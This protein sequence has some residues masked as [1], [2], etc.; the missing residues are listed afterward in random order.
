MIITDL[1]IQHI[2]NAYSKQLSIRPRISKDKD[3]K[4]I[5]PKDQITL[6]TES[7]K[8]WVIDKIAKEII[9][10]LANGGEKSDTGKEILNRLSEEYGHPLEITSDDGKGIMFKV[11]EGEKEGEKLFVSPAENEKL[12][13]RLLDITKTIIYQQLI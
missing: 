8:M 4:N 2:L 11:L 12:K 3:N 5:I 10:Q 9:L 7:K 6:S 1:H 13:E